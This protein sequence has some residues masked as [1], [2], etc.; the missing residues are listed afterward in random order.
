MV[1]NNAWMAILGVAVTVMGVAGCS[2]S[3]QTISPEGQR[4]GTGIVVTGE[5]L[6][7]VPQDRGAVVIASMAKAATAREAS[8][9]ATRQHE[10]FRKELAALKLA[11]QELETAG[12]SV[13]ENVV[14][15]G[16][17]T[18]RDGFKASLSTRVETSDITRL[19][20]VIVVAA[21]VGAVADQG[22]QTFVSSAKLKATREECLETAMR[23][24]G[25]NAARI[26]K[27]ANVRLGA[28]IE[29]SIPDEG[30]VGHYKQAAFA[31]MEAARADAGSAAPAIESRP[32]DL[33][34]N[35]SARYAIE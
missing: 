19:G 9:I 4:S 21:R 24:A 5:C 20:E 25:Q 28:L 27:G 14:Y 35:V 10:A 29:A 7:K 31:P 32:F 12:Y 22:F 15:S 34:V 30:G 3:N 1:A 11:D 2:C 18:T 17:K 23:D 33:N 16:G 8:E 26:A 6:V 13:Y